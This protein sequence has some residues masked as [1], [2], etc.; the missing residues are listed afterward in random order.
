MQASICTSS[1]SSMRA[2]GMPVLH[3]EDHRL[4]RARE[5]GELADG[6]G[7]RLGHAVEP[8]LDLGDDAERAFGADDRAA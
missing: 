1:S 4:H 7:D 3:R 6:G 2:T 8:Q 5:V